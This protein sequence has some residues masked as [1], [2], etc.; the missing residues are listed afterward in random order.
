V[1]K[2]VAV[3]ICALLALA[4]GRA[5]ASPRAD[6]LLK[7]ASRVSGLRIQRAVPRETLTGTRYDRRLQRAGNRAYPPWLRNIDSRLYAQLGLSS[8]S[9]HAV[10]APRGS[11]SPVWYDPFERAL[12][13][14]RGVAAKRAG[15]INELVRALVD[16]H[17]NL[18]RLS[19]LRARDRDRSLAAGGIVNGT[20]ALAS[21]LRPDAV[22]GAQAE[23][24]VK[25]ESADSLKAGK[26]L[27][28]SLRYLGGA[29]AVASALRSFPATTEQLLHIDKFLERERPLA[30]RLPAGVGDLNLRAAETFGELDVRSLLRAFALPNAI[31]I[32]DGWGGGRLALYVTPAGETVTVLVLRW[33]SIE[34]ADEWRDAVP[35]YVAA[36]FP[37][38]PARDCPPLDRCWTASSTVAAGTLGA[39]TVVASGPGANTLAA[40]ALT[41]N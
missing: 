39:T 20:A 11:T 21:G 22:V 35:S 40:A 19:G 33:D 30:V 15:V 3:V 32:A 28:S 24:F 41:E 2:F 8:Q 34:D 5:S 7:S 4:A 27:A 13:L 25:L 17:F 10:V 14:R 37:G 29:R 31:S 12:L 6:A 16:Q 23:R 38:A 1:E 26:A 9:L 36:A 18:R